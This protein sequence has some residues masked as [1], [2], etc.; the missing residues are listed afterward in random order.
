[1]RAL[2]EPALPAAGF[3]LVGGQSRRM[4][5]DKAWLVLD[6]EPLFLRTARLLRVHVASVTLLGPFE[7]YAGFG[8]PVL[9]D[10]GRG[11]LAAL[12]PA[13]A[14]SPCE[15]NL[16]LA[17]DLPFIEGRFVRWLLTRA[18]AGRA[19]AVVPRTAD[20]WQP[21]CAAY[22]RCALPALERARARG[23]GVV[24]ALPE[25]RVDAIDT[26]ELR[27]AGFDEHLLANTNTPAEW[28]RAQQ[29]WA[30]VGK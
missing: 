12:C 15:W 27:Q 5:R 16:V 20:G 14:A 2:R 4:G 26:V 22:H 17:C 11:P 19:E 7:R 1:M 21:L 9:P 30:R 13:L 6:D 18:L 28:A 25:L 23:G 29:V 10:A 8:F 24:A 3:V